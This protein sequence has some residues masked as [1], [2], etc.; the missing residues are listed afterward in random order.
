MPATYRRLLFSTTID[1]SVGRWK[2]F[3]MGKARRRGIS[4]MLL[5]AVVGAALLSAGPSAARGRG[6][7]AEVKDVNGSTI[8]TVRVFVTESG[9]T[10]VKVAGSNLAN[11][12]HGFHVHSVGQCDAAATDASGNASPFF[13]AGGHYNPDTTKTHGSHAGD[14]P[15]LFAA[16]DGTAA[17]AFK[18]D[19][20][21][22][23]HLM[24]AD[25]SAVVIHASP[26]NLAHIP[27]ATS[28][29]GERYHSHVDEVFGPDTAT[30]A[31]GDA[32][33]RFGCGVL[34]K[35]TN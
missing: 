3:V 4:L 29:G 24:D 6:L 35:L 23:A 31:T 2:E 7:V 25:G 8:A 32:G 34:T 27:P 1:E 22:P 17:L 5:S 20:F 12:F 9:K 21:R 28:T 16:A 11:G 15:P 33:S 19:R 18:T 14:M 10:R 13:T 26:D 30:K